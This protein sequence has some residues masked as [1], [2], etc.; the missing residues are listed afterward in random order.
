MTCKNGHNAFSIA[1]ANGLNTFSFSSL[2]QMDVIVAPIA[3]A[4]GHNIFPIAFTNEIISKYFDK[5]C[6]ITG[7]GG[8]THLVDHDY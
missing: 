8:D 4:D 3:L 6:S 2:L 1:L 7:N 5:K